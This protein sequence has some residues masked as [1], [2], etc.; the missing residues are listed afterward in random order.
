MSNK[1][2]EKG[3]LYS[4]VCDD[5]WRRIHLRGELAGAG[6]GIRTHDSLL[7]K[8]YNGFSKLRKGKLPCF[9]TLPNYFALTLFFN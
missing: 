4:G 9:D 2:L 5:Y 1:V 7:G 3:M 6:D 8:H